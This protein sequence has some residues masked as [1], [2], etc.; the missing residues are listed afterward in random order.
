M[1]NSVGTGSECDSQDVVERSTTG[2][3]LWIDWDNASL[4]MNIK[5]LQH[6]S[7]LQLQTRYIGADG[8][9]TKEQS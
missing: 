8:L 2:M 4:T 3:G 5:V 1:F 7:N 9:F 6:L